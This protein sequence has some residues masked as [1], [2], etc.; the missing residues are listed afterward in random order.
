VR[1]F[2]AEDDLKEKPSSSRSPP[3]SPQ[4]RKARQLNT[5]EVGTGFRVMD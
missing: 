5:P 3:R 2:T 4:L 1:A